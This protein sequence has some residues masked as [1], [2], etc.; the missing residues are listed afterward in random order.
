MDEFK[1][2]ILG[3]ASVAFYA[4]AEF[5][6]ML[7]IIISLYISSK[8]RDVQ[9]PRTPEKF[10]WMFLF[11]DNLKRI[12]AG[13]IVLFLLFRFATEFLGRQLNMFWATGIGFFVA[14]GLDQA[15]AAM[16]QKFDFLQMDR[17]KMIQKVIPPNSELVSKSTGETIVSSPPP[18]K[19]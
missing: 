3:D 17:E 12:L 7:A 9:S 1:K 18:T 8:K 16:K 4:A 13:Q 10:S 11:W 2:L 5:F 19:P 6:A 15:I 14:F